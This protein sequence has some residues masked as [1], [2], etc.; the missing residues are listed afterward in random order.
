MRV[1]A[2]ISDA[3]AERFGIADSQVSF[4]T[5]FND[6]TSGLGFMIS[7]LAYLEQKMY[8]RKYANLF[9]DKCVPIVTGEVP[10]WAN[11]VN[12]ISYDSSV[13][14]K[15]IGSHAK[16]LPTVAIERQMHSA[17]L[18]YGGL[19]LRYSLD[20]MRKA[21]HLGM[22]LDAE[23]AVIA[24]RG[25]RE[26]QQHVVFYGSAPEGIRG[27]L[28][29][30]DVTVTTSEL[31]LASATIETLVDEVNKAISEVW[32]NSNQAFLP[33]TICLPSELYSKLANLRLTDTA[34]VMSGL[35]YLKEFSLYK[36]QTGADPEVIP[37]PQLSAKNMG[38]EGLTAKNTL[39]VYDKNPSNLSAWMPIA[40]RF[41][42]PQAEGLEIITPMEYKI[43]GTEFR[44][45]QSAMYLRLAD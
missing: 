40:P 36:E 9:F 26:H 41:I 16:D 15:F 32:V 6:A 44:Y 22:N 45:P 11:N 28:N 21:Q 30:A 20:E 7:Q 19:S 12:Y 2:Q 43:S 39:V 5:R 1:N 29:N 17:N 3:I 34:Q 27:F 25:A 42:A 35:K 37:M 8:E 23:Q 24:Y 4:D 10:E 14:G 18:G 38:A 33:N 31:A 13:K